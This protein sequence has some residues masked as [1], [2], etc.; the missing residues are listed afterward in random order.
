VA[1]PLL[2]GIAWGFSSNR[3]LASMGDYG[4]VTSP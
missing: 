2:I 1:G 4:R 3:A